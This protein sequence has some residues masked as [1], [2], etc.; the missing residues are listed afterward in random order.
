VW[1]N[2]VTKKLS[3][4]WLL[5]Y[6]KLKLSYWIFW[7][8]YFGVKLNNT[9]NFN[10]FFHSTNKMLKKKIGYNNKSSDNSIIVVIQLHCKKQTLKWNKTSCANI[11]VHVNCKFFGWF[12]FLQSKKKKHLSQMHCIKDQV[13][14]DKLS[15]VQSDVS[16][17]DAVQGWL[18]KLT[19][20]M[21]RIWDRNLGGNLSW[22]KDAVTPAT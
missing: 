8:F 5:L 22:R 12:V 13:W 15:T 7:F 20:I 10:A 17:E 3:Q 21:L 19:W 18:V 2:F 16:S 9:N 11:T 6:E 4:T 14:K 1:L